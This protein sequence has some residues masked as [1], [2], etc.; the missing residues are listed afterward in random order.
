MDSADS[1]GLEVPL[2]SFMSVSTYP[3]FSVTKT[4]LL[5]R[6]PTDSK[7]VTTL[8]VALDVA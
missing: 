3:G 2:W 6:S 8:S 4:M 1:G 7:R 5:S